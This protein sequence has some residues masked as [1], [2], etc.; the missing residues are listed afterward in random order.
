VTASSHPATETDSGLWRDPNRPVDERV[1]DLLARMTLEEKVGQ[2]NGVWVGASSD[3]AD[4]APHQHDLAKAPEDWDALQR[5]G[6][7]QFTRPFGTGPVDPALGARALARS[8]AALVAA[9]RFGI[10]AVAH[11]EC[12]AGF[13]AW[14]ATIYPVPLAWGSTFDP[15]LV[16]RMAEQIGTSMRGVG[17]HQGLAPVLDVARDPRWGRCEETIGADPYLVAS[18]GSQYVAGLESSGI[19]ATLKHFAGYSLSSGGRNLAPVSLGRREVVDVLLPSFEAAVREGGA[20]SVMHAYT[21]IDGVPAA[22][23]PDLL[24]SLLRDEWGFTG[25]VVA[26]YFG[27]KFLEILHGIAGGEAEAAALALTAGVDVDLPTRHCYGEPLLRAVHEGLVPEDLV[28]RAARRVLSQKIELG[29]LDP[30]WSPLPAALTGDGDGVEGSVDLDPPAS[31]D[32]ARTLAEKSVILLAISPALPLAPTARIALVGP[33]A[34]DPMAM[35]GCYSFPSHVGVHHP[36]VPMGVSIPTVLESLRRELPGATIDHVKGCEISAPGRDGFGSAVEAAAAAD[37][38]VAVLGDFAALFGRGTSGEGCDAGDLGLPG[39]QGALLEALLGTGKPVVLVLL[40]GR[41]YALGA[42]ADRRA[43]Q[44]L[45]AAA[46]RVPAE[47]VGHHP[48]LPGA[49]AGPGQRGQLGRPDAALPVR[50]RARLH[51]VRV[52]RRRDGRHEHPH[53]RRRVGELRRP[54]HRRAGGQRRRPALP[55]RPGGAGDPARGAA[56]RVRAGRPRPRRGAAR[57]AA[58][59]RGPDVVRGPVRPPRRGARTGGAAARAVVGR[60][61]RDPAGA[62]DR[63]GAAGRLR[64]RLLLRGDG[65]AALLTASPPN[66]HGPRSYRPRAVAA[67]A[68]PSR[69]PGCVRSQVTVARAPVTVGR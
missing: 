44:P 35:L 50:A 9:N 55:A 62:A 10:P 15:S 8:Q 41:P 29:L 23:D 69:G 49:E 34:D 40:S 27:I 26:D 66:G 61:R 67:G 46:H 24:T 12:L 28:D 22:A 59:A 25:T 65:G 37:V 17:V 48:Q 14:G 39:E 43:G 60:R 52:D 7:G 53:R 6:L 20:R 57:P 2:L 42:Y 30:E 18:I 32:H 13:T 64:P 3:G 47:A 51:D 31:Q 58:G 1:D 38:V 4:I 33:N 5:A 54:Q 21:A 36:D 56:R 63:A 19:I 45:G 16:R 11:E 68:S